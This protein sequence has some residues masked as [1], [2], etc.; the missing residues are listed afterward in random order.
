MSQT[1][2]SPSDSQDRPQPRTSTQNPPNQTAAINSVKDHLQAQ[3][4]HLNAQAAL[5]LTEFVTKTRPLV[6][7]D[8]HNDMLCIICSEPFLRGDNP[9]VPVR[10]HCSHI[11]GMNCIL[12]WLSPVSRNGNNSCPICRKPIFDDWDKMNFPPPT[13]SVVAPDLNAR[14]SDVP[15]PQPSASSTPAVSLSA[16]QARIPAATVITT[17]ADAATT[18]ASVT[19]ASSEAV[20][21]DSLL[22]LRQQQQGT[23][24]AR[25]EIEY[26][27]RLLALYNFQQMPYV[28]PPS[29]QARAGEAPST[30]G[31]SERNEE[32]AGRLMEAEVRSRDII[33]S[34][35]PERIRDGERTP[36]AQ[37]S[38]SM[39]TQRESDSA[40]SI[41]NENDPA[42]RLREAETRL[43]EAQTRYDEARTRNIQSTGSLEH[44]VSHEY[45]RLIGASI[46]VDLA[47]SAPVRREGEQRPLNSARGRR[48]NPQREAGGRSET[49][50]PTTRRAAQRPPPPVTPTA[51]STSTPAPEPAPAQATLPSEENTYIGVATMFAAAEADHNHQHQLRQAATTT[52]RKRRLWLQFCEGV[53]RTI[54]HYS[55]LSSSSSRTTALAA[56][57]LDVINMAGLDEFITERA[58]ESP[59]WQRILRTFPRLHTELVTRFDDFRPLPSPSVDV[60]HCMELERRLAKYTTTF[61]VPTLHRARWY[62]RLSERVAA[63]ATSSEEEGHDVAS[64]TERMAVLSRDEG[65]GSGAGAGAST[66]ERQVTT[67]PSSSSSLA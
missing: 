52:E 25:G 24:E 55:P 64:L 62:T 53:V 67:R 35:G 48:R 2:P 50:L 45:R 66:S 31:Q 36:N 21:L 9:E 59:K 46:A 38:P 28:P 1:P 54:E 34:S 61:D 23:P 51:A 17:E 60:A 30:T 10:L 15:V 56:L 63:A 27:R 29:V 20:T 33:S 41:H 57:A 42:R 44:E 22:F 18:S 7:S 16:V 13:R 6:A 40:G 14:T 39:I 3:N 47:V 5:M 26:T 49:L 65:A 43:R 12:K 11:F 32:P 58:A 4:E 37:G 19:T 8:I